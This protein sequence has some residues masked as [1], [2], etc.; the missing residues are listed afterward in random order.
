MRVGDGIEAQ[1][2][3]P[4]HTE[5]RHYQ[6]A[7]VVKELPGGGREL[8]MIGPTGVAEV[9]VL[10]PNPANALAD[11]LRTVQTATPVDLAN[12]TGHGSDGVGQ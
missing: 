2:L 5:V 11:A 9:Y 12:L 3:P 4:I 8:A 1:Q 10:E 7:A 6:T